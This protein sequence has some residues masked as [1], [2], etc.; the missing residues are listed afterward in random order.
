MEP[1]PLLRST[2][3][4]LPGA[5]AVKLKVVLPIKDLP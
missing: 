2:E 1:L 4:L 3:Y 5:K